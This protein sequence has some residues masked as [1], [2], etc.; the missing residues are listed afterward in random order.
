[1]ATIA[2]L[3]GPIVG[4]QLALTGLNFIDT[5]MAGHLGPRELAAV[6]VGASV[7]SSLNMLLLGTLL[8]VPPFVAQLDGAGRLDRVG[9]LAR[10]AAWLAA[11]LGVLLAASAAAVRPLLAAVQV[12]PDLVPLTVGY[13]RALAWGIPAYGLYLVL[14]FTS[15][16]LGATRPVLYFGVLALPVNALG[17]WL[18]MYGKGGLPRLGAVGCGYATAIVWGAQLTGMLLY[19]ALHPRYRH[20]GLFARLEPPRLRRIGELLRV[21]APVAF[22][23]FVEVSIFAAVALIMASLGTRVV[24]GHQVAINFASM[25][26]MVPLGLAMAITVR[27]GNAVGRRDP[28]GVRFSATVGIGMAL[29]FQAVAAAVM[30]LFPRAVA[31]LY[32]DDAGVI[33]IAAE[34]LLLA[35]LFQLSDGLQAAAAGALR[36]VKDTAVPMAIVVVAYWLIGLPLGHALAFRFDLGARGL[37]MGL[38]AGLT[39]AAA[40]LT[41]RF[42]RVAARPE[43]W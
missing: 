11:G 29:A 7:W 5:V 30:L 6:A 27:V 28:A 24:A 42:R 39:A 38:I 20:L 37:W 2:R 1:M 4:G 34:L 13:L 23:L 19:V 12:Q 31:G 43:R 21:G 3:A 18:L 33:A 15:E 25:T 40:L 22:T 17:N 32:T 16:G 14:R 9:P 41:V 26:F 8:A 10:Q 36:G 35:A